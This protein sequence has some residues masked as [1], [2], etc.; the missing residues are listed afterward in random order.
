MK[1]LTNRRIIISGL[2]SYKVNLEELLQPIRIEIE[3]FH[4]II[5]REHV[6]RRGVS[7]SR[8]PG[9]SKDLDKP[10]NARICISSGK[11]EELKELVQQLNCDLIVFV[12]E[13]TKSQQRNLE[14][15]TETEVRV[16]NPISRNF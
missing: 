6:Q 8:K 12:S 9:G 13:L 1:N 14:E 10:L 11:A 3:Q 5:V 7:R 15:L 2:V 4:G 16:C